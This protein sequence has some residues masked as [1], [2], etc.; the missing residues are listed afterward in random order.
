[1]TRSP[2]PQTSVLYRCNPGLFICK[3]INMKSTQ[4]AAS[5]LLAALMAASGAVCAQGSAAGTSSVPAAAGEASTTVQRQTQR[6]PEC[7]DRDE[8]QG[9]AQDGKGN[10]A[11][12]PQVAPRCG[13]DGPERCYLRR[14]SRHAGSVSRRHAAGAGWWHAEIRPCGVL[15]GGR[16]GQDV[17]AVNEKKPGSCD[18]GFFLWVA[19]FE[20]ALT[21]PVMTAP[22]V[23]RFR[24]ECF[25]LLG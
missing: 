15:P 18:A 14:A 6:R 19:L 3:G 8:E 12:R 25:L 16:A 10:E 9:R 7:A 23:R 17:P 21:V 11:R 1:M 4:T 5:I 2:M 24:V 20:P 22:P 13:C